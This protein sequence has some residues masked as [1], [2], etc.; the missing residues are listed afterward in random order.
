MQVEHEEPKLVCLF[1]NISQQPAVGHTQTLVLIPSSY[2]I[3][4]T[5]TSGYGEKPRPQDQ[6]FQESPFLGS[7]G[8][9]GKT[10]PQ[11]KG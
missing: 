3:L 10:G 4:I 5:S 1:A 11:R 7:E 2:N 6:Y 9:P 8:I